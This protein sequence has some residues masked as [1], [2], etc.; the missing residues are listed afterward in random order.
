[1]EPLIIIGILVVGVGLT[2][3]LIIFGLRAS[4]AGGGG[5]G[6]GDIQV[7]LE[8]FAGRTTPL[9]LEEIELSQPF[10][11]R[12]IRPMLVR[13]G[14]ALG[15][16][17]PSKSR[18]AAE[19]RLEMAGRPYGWGATEFFGLRVF[20]ALAFGVLAFLVTSISP[21]AGAMTRII[22]PLLAAMLGFFLP[23]L[24]LGSKIR[25]RKKEIIKSLPDAMDLLTI[26]VE[27]GM[28]FDGAMQKVAEKWNNE[29]SRGFSK[30]V[31]EMRLG[32]IRREALRN[33]SNNM[34]VPDVTSFVA[35][36]I[37]ADQLGVSIAKI[38]RVQS[39]Q[40]RIKRRQRAEEQANKAPIKMLF[41][42]V[43]LIFPA[44]FVVLLGPAV[45][46]L[47]ETFWLS[48]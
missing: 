46:I 12:V 16:L 44:L 40:M 23:I 3:A 6:G 1:M 48:Q 8:E 31:Q 19:R 42:M 21:S 43:F 11:Q 35:A 15:R 26:A 34:D 10:S 22:A 47:M 30:V 17:S 2:G 29:L 39:E 13:I 36:I 25:K 37:Q 24:W 9:T 20:V 7:R 18:A 5:G 33:M 38:L 32:V 45:I 41:P 27:A 14:N 4:A 28:G